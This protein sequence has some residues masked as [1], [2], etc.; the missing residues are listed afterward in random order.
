[1][2]LRTKSTQ[3]VHYQI[4][5]STGGGVVGINSTDL[6]KEM[7]RWVNRTQ[8]NTFF[9]VFANLSMKEIYLKNAK[10]SQKASIQSTLDPIFPRGHNVPPPHILLNNSRKQRATDMKFLDNKS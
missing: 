10:S 1:M 7:G 5:V 6:N 9:N 8:Q 3:T 2:I 4:L